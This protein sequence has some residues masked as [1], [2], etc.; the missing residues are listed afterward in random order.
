M[1]LITILIYISFFKFLFLIPYLTSHWNPWHIFFSSHPLLLESNSIVLSSG[2]AV[3]QA[4]WLGWRSLEDP[5]PRGS[6]TL[7]PT[8]TLLSSPPCT[9]WF[10]LPESHPFYSLFLKVKSL[11]FRCIPTMRLAGCRRW[12]PGCCSWW[13][14]QRYV[15]SWNS[16][17]I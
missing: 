14:R 12:K 8:P 1:V 5:K 9:A 2:S 10:H 17:L 16:E 3:D 11:D 6:L 13:Q 15:D 7:A 4:C